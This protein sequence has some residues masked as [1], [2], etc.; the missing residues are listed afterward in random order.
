MAGEGLFVS[1]RSLRLPCFISTSTLQRQRHLVADACCVPD[2]SI[3]QPVIYR[4]P[5]G[6]DHSLRG[7][8][9][10][11]E[12]RGGQTKGRREHLG[13]PEHYARPKLRHHVGNGRFLEL[14]LDQRHDALLPGL[15][16]IRFA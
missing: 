5:N 15:I 3:P 7:G 13:L 11:K 10:L 16:A 14:S 4:L 12:K 1:N 8:L 9:T 2:A 6:Q